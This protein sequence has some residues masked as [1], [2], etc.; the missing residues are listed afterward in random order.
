M[1]IILFFGFI[2]IGAIASADD[3]SFD[4]YQSIVDRQMFG[5]PPVG[6]DPTKPPSEVSKKEQKELTKEQ[7]QIKSSVHFSVINI[8]PDGA[9]AV[10]FTDSSDAKNP[11]HYYLKVG[12]SRDGWTVS[13][14]DAARAWMK[15]VKDD[16]EVELT[17]GGNSSQGAG[18]TSRAGTPMTLEARSSAQAAPRSGLLGSGSLLSR[19]RN[20]ERLR[21]EEQAKHEAEKEKW[22]QQRQELQ[23]QMLQLSETIKAKAAADKSA[24]IPQNREGDNA[25]NNAEPVQE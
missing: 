2:V 22:E 20:R 7:E 12:E 14:A 17:L 6:F 15:I 18:T 21:A 10:G 1:K 13:E 3:G 19:R 23:E 4:R 11:R 8:T 5:R 24:A 25:E 9:T 16:I